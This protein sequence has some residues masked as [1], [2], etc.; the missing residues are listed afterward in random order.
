MVVQNK[1][2]RACVF[3]AC[4][5]VARISRDAREAAHN[6]AST[7]LPLFAHLAWRMEIGPL[8]WA[9][10]GGGALAAGLN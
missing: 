7:Y 1:Y 4:C 9:L 3:S 5:R 10:L 2:A 8:A 6:R